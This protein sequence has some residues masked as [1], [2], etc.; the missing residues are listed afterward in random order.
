[1]GLPT[2]RCRCAAT[3]ISQWS[4]SRLARLGHRCSPSRSVCGAPSGPWRPSIPAVLMLSTCM[5][6]GAI[7]HSFDDKSIVC[8]SN[9]LF[10][11][12]TI[13]SFVSCDDQIKLNEIADPYEAKI[14]HSSNSLQH[15]ISPNLSAK[16]CKFLK[17]PS[18]TR[19]IV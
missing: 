4:Q 14:I 7:T 5:L 13:I 10:L 2:L 15:D 8:C 9:L 17:F 3:S 11:I 1:M 12:Y 16:T 19:H 6:D 18:F